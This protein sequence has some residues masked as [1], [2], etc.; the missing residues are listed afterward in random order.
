MQDLKIL[1]LQ[2][3]IISNDPE[4]NRELFEINYQYEDIKEYL[5]KDISSFREIAQKYYLYE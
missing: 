1:C 5:K 4:K 3:D 2:A